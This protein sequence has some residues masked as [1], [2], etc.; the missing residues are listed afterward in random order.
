MV[1]IGAA[2]ALT[3]AAL[4][5]LGVSFFV[6]GMVLL[7]RGG[8]KDAGPIFF[9]SGGITAILALILLIFAMNGFFIGTLSSTAA[10][11]LVTVAFVLL[12]FAS[13]WLVAGTVAMKGYDTVP[14]GSLGIFFGITMIPV[15]VFLW[16][17]PLG[18]GQYWLTMNTILWIWV[19]FT[20]PL[21]FMFKVISGK[22]AGWSFLAEALI[23]LWIPATLIL[24]GIKLP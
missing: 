12:V 2:E 21:A 7:G 10:G 1:V 18:F 13:T 20:L 5:F 14:L 23:T 11:P 4:M 9:A 17:N 24:L 16:G 3:A 8:L 19:F 22:V 6:L 15:A